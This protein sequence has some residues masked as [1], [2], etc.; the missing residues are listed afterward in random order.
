MNNP[1]IAQVLQQDTA[2]LQTL[3][4]KGTPSFFVNGTPLHDFGAPQLKAL[5]DQEIAKA[6]TP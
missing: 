6:K 1:A 4:V 2:D 5:V 3:K